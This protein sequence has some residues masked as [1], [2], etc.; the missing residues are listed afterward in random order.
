MFCHGIYLKCWQI[1]LC[2]QHSYVY[3]RFKQWCTVTDDLLI[4]K[5]Q[6]GKC[7]YIDLNSQVGELYGERSLKKNL[8]CASLILKYQCLLRKK[9]L[10]KPVLSAQLV[11]CYY[12]KD[13]KLNNRSRRIVKNTVISVCAKRLFPFLIFASCHTE[14]SA[15]CFPGLLARNQT[16]V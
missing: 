1:C 5:T 4:K 16:P 11:L 2:L 10:L 9:H 13:L 7:I 14:A 6:I 15:C 8:S 12:V 3:L